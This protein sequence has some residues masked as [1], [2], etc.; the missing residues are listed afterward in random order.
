MQAQKCTHFH[1][2]LFLVRLRTHAHIHINAAPPAAIKYIYLREFYSSVGK[3]EKKHFFLVHYFK[4]HMLRRGAM[5][6]VARIESAAVY[7][8]QKY[9]K[10]I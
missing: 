5:L 1:Q 9:Y 6:F 10:S 4:L 7:E 2:K 3:Y 8:G